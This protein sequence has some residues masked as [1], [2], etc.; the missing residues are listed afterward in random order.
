MVHIHK[1][2][3]RALNERAKDAVPSLVHWAKYLR[4]EIT[5]QSRPPEQRTGVHRFIEEPLPETIML[6]LK[7]ND[8]ENL[9]DALRTHARELAKFTI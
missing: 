9:I 8:L 2:T 3:A 7:R 6:T 5:A 1:Q 4:A